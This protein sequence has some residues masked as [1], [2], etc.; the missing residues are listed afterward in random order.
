MLKRLWKSL[1]SSGGG[2]DYWFYVRCDRC[3]EVLQGR[4]DMMNDLSL[5][6]AEDDRGDYYFT[7][8]VLMGSKRCFQRIEAEFEFDRGRKLLTKDVTGGIFVSEEDYTASI[9][10]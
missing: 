4:I 10:D 6:Y 9:R 2:R 3:G 7:R 8:K 1:T 5:V